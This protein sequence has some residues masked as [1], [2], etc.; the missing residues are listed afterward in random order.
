MADVP[1]VSCASV[2][3]QIRLATHAPWAWVLVIIIDWGVSARHRRPFVGQ[4]IAARCHCVE[5]CECMLRL[6]VRQLQRRSLLVS[7]FE[8]DMVVNRRCAAFNVTF[9]FYAPGGLPLPPR[10]PTMQ[11]A[12]GVP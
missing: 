11:E 12:A 5:V 9:N 10:P 1:T 8:N 7:R 6:F 4:Y 2:V 3:V